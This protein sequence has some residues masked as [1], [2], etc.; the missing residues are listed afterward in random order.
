M[1]ITKKKFWKVLKEPAQKDCFN[2]VHAEVEKIEDPCWS[3]IALDTVNNWKYDG[4][5]K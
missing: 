4:K 3:C 5:T 2:C 1:P